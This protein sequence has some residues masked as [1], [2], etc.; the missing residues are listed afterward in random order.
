MVDALSM[1]V[2]I[3]NIETCWSYFKKGNGV[4]GD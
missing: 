4:G 1:H 2:W 3:G